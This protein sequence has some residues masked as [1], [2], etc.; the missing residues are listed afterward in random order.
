[1][2][3]QTT[4]FTNSILAL[5]KPC[6][7]HANDLGRW[8][9]QRENLLKMSKIQIGLLDGLNQKY[10]PDGIRTNDGD[11]ALEKDPI[12]IRA[13]AQ[14]DQI[15]ERLIAIRKSIADAQTSLG[16]AIKALR[17]ENNKFEQFIKA[18]KS[19]WLKIKKSVPEAEHCIQETKDLIKK[20][21][22]LFY[23]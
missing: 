9:P 23:A 12:F 15:H 7:D 20:C 3:K 2:G 19:K 11:D 16:G 10:F 21:E 6:I 13:G 5:S 18:K 1:M 22:T 17:D 4:A 8:I 14:L